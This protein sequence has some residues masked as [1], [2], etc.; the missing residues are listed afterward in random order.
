MPLYRAPAGRSGTP[1]SLRLLLATALFA[2]PALSGCAGLR[3]EPPA[4]SHNMRSTTTESIPT[5]MDDRA[6]QIESNLGVR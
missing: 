1:T 5:G 4:P 2:L 3:R 6:R